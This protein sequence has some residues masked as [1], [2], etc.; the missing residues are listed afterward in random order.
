[1]Q[2]RA[3]VYGIALIIF[4]VIHTLA[5]PITYG[6]TPYYVADVVAYSESQNPNLLWEF[7]HLLWRPL[8]YSLWVATQPLF[9]RWFA[10]VRPQI[11]GA[12]IILST[13]SG[14]AV[15]VVSAAIG[16]SLNLSKMTTC[17]VTL[18]VVCT[19][20]I[21]IWSL[22]GAA[23]VT[24]FFLQLLSIYLIVNTTKRPRPTSV[25]YVFSGAL[26]GFSVLTWFPY[27]L[28]IPAIALFAYAW[29]RN[30]WTLRSTE[31]V[32]RLRCALIVGI[33][34]TALVGISYLIV[35]LALGI[36]APAD[37]AAWVKRSAHGMSQTHG[38]L[39]IATGLPRSFIDLGRD[40][41]LLKRF[42]F[43][44]PYATTS[45][46]HLLRFSA[47]KIPLI[48]CGLATLIWKLYWSRDKWGILPPLFTAS[49]PVLVFAIFVFEASSP[50][51][52]LPAVTL[53]L[54]GICIATRDMRLEHH[55]DRLLAVCAGSIVIVNICSYTKPSSIYESTVNRIESM[56]SQLTPQSRVVLLSMADDI[57]RFYH[58]S[59]FHKLARERH[60]PIYSF[61]I[62]GDPFQSFASLAKKTWE[63]GGDLWI[64]CRVWAERPNAEWEWVEGDNSKLSWKKLRSYFRNLETGRTI[65]GIDGF[66]VVPGT[67]RNRRLITPP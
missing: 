63:N 44:D 2:E 26:A 23:Y 20:S 3:S 58:N 27:V 38:L 54:P 19:N 49:V 24:G 25:T 18:L 35:A 45:L 32:A 57:P 14:A 56:R 17:A 11:F 6:D 37:V 15:A 9:A 46:L 22:S 30:D 4:A 31:A 16:R 55:S 13:L 61:T 8:G 66:I 51:R 48:Y 41:I 33:T 65:G 60:L 5:G 39:R 47:W 42:V 64:S 52:Y 40:G 21:F 50:E 34:S 10:D 43:G 1:M 12:F 36:T 62:S 59:P 7:G 67:Q 28:S 53:L 29:G